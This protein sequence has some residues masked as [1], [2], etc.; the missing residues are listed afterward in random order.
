MGTGIKKYTKKDLIHE[1]WK[2]SPIEKACLDT[3]PYMKYPQPI[4]NNLASA[5][6]AKEKIWAIKK[7]QKLR[8]FLKLFWKNMQA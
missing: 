8:S 3:D 4:V 6:L 1:P 2:I 7:T 5:R